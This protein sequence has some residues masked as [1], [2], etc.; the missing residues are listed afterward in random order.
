MKFFR[1]LRV[2]DNE[3]GATMTEFVITLPIFVMSFVGILHLHGIQDLAIQGQSTAYARGMEHFKEIQTDWIPFDWVIH[4]VLGA[5]RA[6][7]YHSETSSGR[8]LAADAVFDSVPIGAGHMMESYSRALLA[9][10]PSDTAQTMEIEPAKLHMSVP[11]VTSEIETDFGNQ[12]TFTNDWN[13]DLVNLGGFDNGQGWTGFVNGFLDTAGARPALAAGLR[14]GVAE[15]KFDETRSFM[16]RDWKVE[17]Y[18]HIAAPTRPTSKWISFAVARLYLA[19]D[20]AYNHKMLA[21]E[22]DLST[23]ADTGDTEDCMSQMEGITSGSFGLSDA[24]DSMDLL[25]DIRGGGACG[26]ANASSAGGNVL[27]F[28]NNVIGNAGEFFEGPVPTNPASISP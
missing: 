24:M 12:V 5:G 15:G 21:F 28:F 10:P 2:W 25:R 19:D 3:D 16:G 8:D 17:T 14:Y 22:M 1:R 13:S 11:S 26:G 23:S 7:V 4:P 20:E 9:G 18:Q 6:V 27:D